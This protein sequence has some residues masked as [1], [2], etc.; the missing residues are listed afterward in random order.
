MRLINTHTGHFEEFIGKKIPRYAVLSHTWGKDEVSFHDKASDPDFVHKE[1]FQKIAATCKLAAAAEI[2]YAWVDTCCIDKSS[3]AELS[4]AINSM[5][6]WYERSEICYVFLSDLDAA[7]ELKTELRRCYWF[8]RGWTLQELIAPSNVVFFDRDWNKRGDKSSL[9]D[10]LSAITGI[11]A[12][13][14]DHTLPLSAIAVAQKMSWAAHRST[15]R[16]EDT[17][18]C[19][20][21]IFGIHMP[22]MY[23]EE[24]VSFERLQQ[25]IIHTTADLSIFA[26]QL[27][28]LE[29]DSTATADSKPRK[30]MYC[31]FLA[32]SPAAFSQS[33]AFEKQRTGGLRQFSNSNCGIKTRVQTWSYLV[34]LTGERCHLFPVDCSGADGSLLGVRIKKCG[35]DQFIRENPWDLVEVDSTGFLTSNPISQRFLVTDISEM[36][37]ESSSRLIDSKALSKIRTSILQLEMSGPIESLGVWPSARFDRQEQV[38]MATDS[39]L[40]DSCFIT[41]GVWANMTQFGRRLPKEHVFRAVCFVVG[42]SYLEER[43][44]QVTL[45]DYGENP[46]IPDVLAK[47]KSGDLDSRQLLRRLKFTGI[48][49]VPE[50]VFAIPDTSLF[51][52][53]YWALS[54]QEDEEICAKPFW[55]LQI[56]SEI[57]DEKSLRLIRVGEWAFNA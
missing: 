6:R 14:L 47:I 31:G 50:I 38:F 7:A 19:L 30:Q 57:C 2:S 32:E 35:H 36:A 3:S 18:Y 42:W 56:S 11:N 53:V 48:R 22:L 25:Q 4:E 13:I 43:L 23:G 8:T 46:M 54:R 1:G 24:E 45:V 26:W 15:T 27:P 55:R 16:V 52:R 49:K 44:P 12:A 40:N 17:A 37:L 20:L 29:H 10:D 33:G 5:Y 41:L 34:P 21:G 51:A 28:V 9:L 39:H